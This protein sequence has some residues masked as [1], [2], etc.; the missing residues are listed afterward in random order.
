MDGVKVARLESKLNNYVPDRRGNESL[1]Y[2]RANSQNLFD[3]IIQPAIVPGSKFSS[4][5]KLSQP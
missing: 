1:T 3:K 5:L 4:F 2:P